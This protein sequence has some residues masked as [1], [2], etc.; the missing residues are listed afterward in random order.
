MLPPSIP[1]SQPVRSPKFG[2][3][4]SPST[5]HVHAKYDVLVWFEICELGKQHHWNLTL[6]YIL[7][8]TLWQLAACF[9]LVSRLTYSLTLKIEATCSS[10]TSVDFWWTTWRYT[11]EDR[12]LHNHRC[13][14]IKSYKEFLWFLFD[15]WQWLTRTSSLMDVIMLI[16]SICQCVTEFS[17][18]DLSLDHLR[19]S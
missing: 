13:E 14:N 9:M 1:I 19:N 5:S 16:F 3:L 7:A 6:D 11:P 12:T 15:H 4:P 17:E 8:S 10:K 2:V 18:C